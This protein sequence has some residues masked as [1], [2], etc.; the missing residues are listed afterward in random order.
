MFSTV[1][2]ANRGE[3]ALRVMRACRELGLRTVAVYSEADRDALHVRYADQAELIGPPAPADSYLNIEAILDAARRSRAGAI[4]PGYGFLAENAAF[5][6]A[7]SA[8]GLVFIGPS[9][10]AMQRM[11]GK[12]Q[13]RR[14]AGA[15]GVP[16]VPGTTDPVADPEAVLRL[17]EQIGYPIAIK[18]SAGGGGRGL[19][20]AATP[21]DVPEAFAGARREAAAYFKSEELYVERYL[22]NP[23][24]IEVQILADAHGTVLH[25]G[26]RD[27][28]VQR[29]HQKLIEEAPS[30]IL[31]TGER[32]ELGAAATRLARHVGYTGAGTLE[33]LWEAGRFYFLEMNTRIQVEH[34]VTEAITGIDLVK[35]QIL[36]AQGQPLPWRQDEIFFQGHAIECR[37]NAEDPTA[38]F[39]PSLG[40]LTTYH[41]PHGLG[42]RVESGYRGGM[43]IPPQYDSLVAKLITW[44]QSRDEALARMR[45]AVDD[46]E[47][48]GVRTTLPFHRLALQHP[49]FTAGD[50][51][52]RFI[53]EHISEE[54]L[55]ALGGPPDSPPVTDDLA[56]ARGFEVEVNG[57]RFA[58]R[59]AEAGVPA[60]RPQNPR[61]GAGSGR[62]GAATARA[63]GVTAPMGGTVAAVRVAPGESVTAGQVLVVVEAMK[64]ENE[65][66]APHAGTIG[67]VRAA[68]GTT[69]QIGDTLLTFV[70]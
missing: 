36:V 66:A 40:T 4:H 38:Q 45:R 37:V 43:T 57:R 2:V 33:F 13:A 9:A 26:E 65:I 21:A 41:E 64:M 46:F 23:R 34:T 61:R 68:P 62:Q 59:V 12:V 49:V 10:E 58:V 31:G 1:L 60:G 22:A 16:V 7:C 55:R 39:R 19:K 44:G 29:R 3:I 15:A 27:C 8:A 63:D 32:A 17:A 70:A 30:P 25:L 51:T 50:A 6:Q 35:W 24:H 53:E 48:A 69:V 11:G 5:A 18:A 52:V 20:V 47:I 56:D 42:V 54:A 28:S 14:E 67:E